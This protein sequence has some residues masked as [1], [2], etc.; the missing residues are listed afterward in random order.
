MYEYLI[1]IDT[2]KAEQLSQFTVIADSHE[3]TGARGPDLLYQFFVGTDIVA[4]AMCVVLWM[5]IPVDA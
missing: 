4:E 5:R 1:V 2:Q 3:T